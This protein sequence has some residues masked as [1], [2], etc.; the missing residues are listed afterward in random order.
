MMSFGAPADLLLETQEAAA[1]EVRH[2]RRALEIASALS[3]IQLTFG[4]L[5]VEA[6]N[7]NVTRAQLIEGLIREAC[8]SETLGVGEVI[9]AA[10]LC[11][12]PQIRAHLLEVAED[13]SRHANLAWRSLSWLIESAPASER[14]ALTDLVT[15]VFSSLITMFTQERERQ[16][17]SD[18][19]MEIKALNGVGILSPAQAFE[20]RLRTYQEVILPCLNQ[21][22][23]LTA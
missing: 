21:L 20:A 23:A 14:V 12:E 7:L 1:D 6:L 2:A 19:E 17:T 13:E 10:R 22:W 5:P 3:G 16:S 9:E 18:L 15:D 4:E 8:F 11:A